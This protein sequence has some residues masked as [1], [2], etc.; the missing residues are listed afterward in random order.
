MKRPDRTFTN[1]SKVKVEQS[2]MYR[3]FMMHGGNAAASR[4]MITSPSSQM[5]RVN[6]NSRI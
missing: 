5:S 4:G 2:H 6:L 1:L 3:E